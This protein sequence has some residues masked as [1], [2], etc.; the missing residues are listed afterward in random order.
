[1]IK[2]T[3]YGSDAR[4]FYNTNCFPYTY[5]QNNVNQKNK[6]AFTDK[7]LAHFEMHCIWR[8]ASSALLTFSSGFI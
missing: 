5:Q 1:M 3:K 6:I 8:T 7:N 4:V 2:T